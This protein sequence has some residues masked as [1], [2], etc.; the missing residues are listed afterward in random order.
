[1]A[2]GHVQLEIVGL[3]A[4]YDRRRPV[5][6]DVSCQILAGEVLGL[7]EANGAGKTTL[8]NSICAVHRGMSVE[9]FLL[10]GEPT[11]PRSTG[12]KRS[13]YLSLTDDSS[14]PTWRLPTLIRSMER[15]YRIPHD[16]AR[17]DELIHGFGFDTYASSV[18]SELSSG[19]RK[20]ANLITAFY[21][22]TPLLFLD[23]PVDFLDFTATEFLYSSI[24]E[25]STRGRTVLLSSHVAESFTRCC[26]RVCA[27]RDGVLTGPFPTPGNPHDVAALIQ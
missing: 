15:A 13:R 22:G 25:A 2:R 20:K 11:S 10:D 17:L 26:H 4:W 7:L 19:S 23:E 9:G 21:T 14:F 18:F 12:F 5:L 1:M 16:T 24:K 3:T 8:L 6:T 27:L